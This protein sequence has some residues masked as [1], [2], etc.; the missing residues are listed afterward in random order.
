[1]PEEGLQG[2]QQAS[3]NRCCSAQSPPRSNGD[4]GPVAEEGDHVVDL[5]DASR[6]QGRG[7]R[8]ATNLSRCANIWI[9]TSSAAQSSS[10]STCE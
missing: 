6:P 2:G 7:H 9:E 1:M 10:R 8:A 5:V 3:P 4:H